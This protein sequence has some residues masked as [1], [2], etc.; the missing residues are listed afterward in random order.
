ML[1]A[2]IAFA[3]YSILLKRKPKELSIRAFQLST[4]ILGLIFLFPFFILEH[5]TV[6]PVEFDTRTVSSILYVGVFASLLAFG[7]WNKAIA[8][9]G[10][11]KAGMVYYTLPLFSGLWAYLFLKEDIGMIHVYSVLLIV[12]GVLT[13]NYE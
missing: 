5:S 6:P 13:A 11:S 7:L 9:V 1:V 3:I 4:F 8:T 12:S 10:P 2:S